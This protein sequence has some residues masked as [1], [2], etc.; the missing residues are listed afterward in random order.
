M[1]IITN[2]FLLAHGIRNR[3]SK[4][5]KLDDDLKK[6]RIEM[7]SRSVNQAASLK[8]LKEQMRSSTKMMSGTRNKNVRKLLAEKQQQVKEC[9]ANLSLRTHKRHGVLVDFNR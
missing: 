6:K 4:R 9:L 8:F 7:H 2:I 3:S 1:M 5:Q